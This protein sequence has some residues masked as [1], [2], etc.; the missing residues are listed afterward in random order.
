MAYV[1][2][3]KLSNIADIGVNLPA[4]ELKQG[5]W[6]VVAT[7]KIVAPMR[8]TFKFL[9]LQ[10]ISASVDTDDVVGANKTFGNLGLAYVVLRRDYTG[11]NPGAAGGL[12]AVIATGLGVTERTGNQV[13]F[14]TAGFYSFI[15]AN[16]MQASTDESVIIPAST[17]IDFRLSVTGHARIEY[18]SR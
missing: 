10:I 15:V 4:T 2:E 6:L 1:T 12:D 3:N 5:D 11:G 13:R 7:V 8:L 14:D 9:N 18:D 16:N 17:S